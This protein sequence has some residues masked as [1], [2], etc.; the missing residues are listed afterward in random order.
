MKKLLRSA[1]VLSLLFTVTFLTSC[2][3]SNEKLIND[4]ELIEK[5]ELGGDPV[6]DEETGDE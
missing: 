2:T 4:T 5:E 1:L 6:D 3:D